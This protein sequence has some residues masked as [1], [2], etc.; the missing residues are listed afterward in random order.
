MNNLDSEANMPTQLTYL[1]LRCRRDLW[2]EC[3]SEWLSLLCR[4]RATMLLL[5]TDA[6]CTELW[7]RLASACRRCTSRHCVVESINSALPLRMEE[8]R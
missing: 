2:C 3:V 1:F 7:P 4:L 6:C 8:L 5:D